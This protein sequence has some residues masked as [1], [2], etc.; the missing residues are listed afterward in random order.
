VIGPSRI[1]R[2]TNLGQAWAMPALSVLSAVVHGRKRGAEEIVRAALAAACPALDSEQAKVY[3]HY[4]G[5]L[6]SA[7]RLRAPEVPMR[8]IANRPPES[9]SLDDPY[10][11]HWI[12]KGEELG[13]QRGRAE[14]L[15]Q[16]LIELLTERFGALP[17]TALA[18]IDEADGD[19]LV[20]W[21]RRVLSAA[22]LDQVL[23]SAA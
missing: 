23:A 4:L 8:L 15:R 18:R 16:L 2:I 13:E 3:A 17:E 12:A 19:L 20:H 5:T 21:G 11:R 14:A 22:S 10:A 9:F 1:P 7:E 6:P